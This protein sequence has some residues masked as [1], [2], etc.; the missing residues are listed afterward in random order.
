MNNWE[1]FFDSSYFD[2]WV[3]RKKDDKNFNSP[4]I[5]HLLKRREAETLC[6]LLNELNK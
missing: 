2:M 6:N 4:L 3:V 1:T 5:F